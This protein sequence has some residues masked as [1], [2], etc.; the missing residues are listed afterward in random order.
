M[1]RVDPGLRQEILSILEGANDMTI[2]TTRE[3][4]YPQ[5]TTVNYVS[6]GLAIYFGCA[7]EPQKAIN[8]ARSDKVSL[9]VNLPYSSWEEMRGPRVSYFVSWIF[10]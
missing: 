1:Q 3:D 10:R 8:I 9:T 6:D 5:A 4:G 2:A 7:A